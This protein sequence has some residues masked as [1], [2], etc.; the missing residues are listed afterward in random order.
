MILVGSAIIVVSA[1]VVSAVVVSAV[2]VVGV[3][4]A[5]FVSFVGERTIWAALQEAA[6]ASAISVLLPQE[7][8]L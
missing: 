7:R 1:V 3:S 2:S 5:S 6:E 4:V 8:G